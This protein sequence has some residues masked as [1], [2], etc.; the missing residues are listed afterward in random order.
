MKKFLALYN[1][2][3]SPQTVQMSE[4]D[5]NRG[6]AAWGQWM[7]DNNSV[8]VDAGGPLGKTKRTGKDGVTDI[9]NEVGGYIIVQAESHEA[10][11][12]LF[13]GHPHFTIFPGDRVEV[14][15]VLP[16]PGG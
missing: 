13:E 2:S 7:M 11:A 15:E 1:G 3:V 12:R 16:M 4:A 5:M 10:A 14:M 6:M 8:I 9:R